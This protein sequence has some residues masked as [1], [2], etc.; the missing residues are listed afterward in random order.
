MR[1]SFAA[2]AAVL[3]CGTAF[4]AAKTGSYEGSAAGLKGS[5]K[6][7]LVG[8]YDPDDKTYSDY[9][10]V[11]YMKVTISKGSSYSIWTDPNEDISLDV[12]TN[13]EDAWVDFDGDSLDD[14]TQ[15]ARLAAS[16]WE[17][18][19]P[20]KVTFFVVVSGDIG[21]SAT[22]YSQNSWR[23]FVPVGVEDNKYKLSFTESPKT[24]S[25]VT[26]KRSLYR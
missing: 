4:G 14:G 18:E 6:V 17:A 1:F 13:N 15:Y 2:L 21:S 20:S 26:R 12:Y 25:S 9:S 5:Q 7:T 24:A 19:D 3:A 16:D 11:Y 22:V 10:G 8:E 23:S